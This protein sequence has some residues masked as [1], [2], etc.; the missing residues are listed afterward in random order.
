LKSNVSKHSHARG[1]C[2]HPSTDVHSHDHAGILT[3]LEGCEMVICAGMGHRAAEALKGRGMQIV[4]AAP[5][6]ADETVAAYLGGKLSAKEAG[7]CRCGRYLFLHNK[8]PIL[9]LGGESC[10]QP[11]LQRNSSDGVCEPSNCWLKVIPPWK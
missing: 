1:E 3:T 6:P 9:R 11:E 8:C 4:F 5:G 2:K 10:A 7:F